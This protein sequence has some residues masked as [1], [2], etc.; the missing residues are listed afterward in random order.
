[1][2][3][4][5]VVVWSPKSTTPSAEAA[6]TPPKTG[7]ETVSPSAEALRAPIL[8]KEGCRGFARW[9][10]SSEES[11]SYLTTC[12]HFIEKHH[13]VSRSGCHPSYDR[14][15][16]TILPSFVHKNTNRRF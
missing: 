13:S 6:A 4:P 2:L 8:V 5:P 15:G 1:M 3:L 9:G 12:D 10:G 7:G 14:R 16:T 11:D